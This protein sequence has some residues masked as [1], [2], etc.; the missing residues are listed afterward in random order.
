MGLFVFFF[1]N[2][3]VG[4]SEAH[5]VNCLEQVSKEYDYYS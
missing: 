4:S 1:P 5:S 3:D 2:G